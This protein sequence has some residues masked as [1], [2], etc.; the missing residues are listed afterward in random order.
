MKFC[1]EILIKTFALT[2]RKD[3]VFFIHQETFMYNIICENEKMVHVYIYI[4][5]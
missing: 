5:I 2:G 3:V 4:Y 1:D